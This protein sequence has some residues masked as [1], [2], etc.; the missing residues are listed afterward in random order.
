MNHRRGAI[1]VLGLRPV[2][3]AAGL[4][5]TGRARALWRLFR[6]GVHPGPANLSRRFAAE[7]LADV[8]L[9]PVRVLETRRARCNTHKLVLGLHDG[10]LVETVLIPAVGA[11][12]PRTTVCVSSQVGCARAC[13]FC[14]TA[15]MG[16][17]RSLQASEIVGQVVLAI[18]AAASLHL[19]PVRNVVFMGMGEPLDNLVEVRQ[20]LEVLVDPLALALAPRHIT[21]STVGTTPRAI[22]AAG[23]LPG[24]LAWSVHAVDDGVRRQLVPTA[25][26]PMRELG[27]AF[28]GVSVRRRQHLLIEVTLI[29]GMNDRPEH[30]EA[31]ADFF[32]AFAPAP[33]MNLLPLNEGRPG[34]HAASREAIEAFRAVL[35]ARGYFCAVREARGTDEGAACGQLAT[36]TRR[37]AEIDAPAI[38]AGA[39]SPACGRS[40]PRT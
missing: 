7:R 26:A 8:D 16:L 15:T 36:N 29:E 39:G 37:A 2:Q 21:V 27:E 14:V 10:G 13:I 4:G 23:D 38:T 28:R 9:D 5:G 12:A 34:L 18:R 30:A 25:R 1:D 31:M 19:P 24:F 20:A 17:V 32:A 11:G 35:H 3:A 22:A 33:R 6:S 40:D